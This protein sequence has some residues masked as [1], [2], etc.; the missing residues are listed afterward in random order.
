[1]AKV[2]VVYES[3]YG[4]TKGELPKCKEFGSNIA[5]KL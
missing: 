5:I 1:M 3:K 4:N 2:M